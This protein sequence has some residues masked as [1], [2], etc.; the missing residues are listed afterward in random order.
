MDNRSSWQQLG[1][2]ASPIDR[3]L[4]CQSV[5]QY[6]TMSAANCQVEYSDYADAGVMENGA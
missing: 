6:I 5:H 2:D 4:I 3:K 1:F